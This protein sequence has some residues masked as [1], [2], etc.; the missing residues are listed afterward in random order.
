MNQH[1]QNI[2]D[3][4]QQNEKLS[5]EEKEQFLKILKKADNDFII[6]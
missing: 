6:S 3:S 5:A 1:L 4:V 2:F